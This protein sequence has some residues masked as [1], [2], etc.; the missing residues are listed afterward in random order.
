MEEII[1]E[2]IQREKQTGRFNEIGFV[3]G[4]IYGD[5]IESA[6]SVKFDEK[7]LKKVLNVHGSHAKIWIKFNNEKK[8]G[9]IKEVQRKPMSGA[10]TH[11]D[12]QIVSKN[13]EIK[14]QI[15]I[16]FKGEDDLRNI[17]LTLQIYK[18]ETT[19]FGKIALMPD[20]I[21]VDVSEMKLGDTVIFETFNLNKELKNDSEDTVYGMVVNVR[22]QIVEEEDADATVDAAATVTDAEAKEATK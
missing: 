14:R 19:V 9:F 1:L 17:Q 16:I 10:L 22:E 4:V 7:E 18:S 2:A 8:F 13:H 15:P 5:S 20:T 6:N 21:H 11:I 3:P 12:V